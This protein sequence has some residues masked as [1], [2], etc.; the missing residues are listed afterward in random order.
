MIEKNFRNLLYCALSS[1]LLVGCDDG[2][3]VVSAGH[4]VDR[5][6]GIFATTMRS[7]DA[8]GTEVL[9]SGF[10]KVL[11][12]KR[13]STETAL[14]SGVFTYVDELWVGLQ[15]TTGEYIPESIWFGG[16]G[17]GTKPWLTHNTYYWPD[18][19]IACDF[20]AVYPTSGPDI[21]V[22][23]RVGAK[24]PVRYLD[25]NNGNGKTDL[26]LAATTSNKTQAV[27]DALAAGGT[28]GLAKLLFHHSLSRVTL[29]AKL[30]ADQVPQLSVTVNSVEL[31][32]VLQMGTF[33]F[34]DLPNNPGDAPLIGVWTAWGVPQSMILYNDAT[35]VTLT[36]AAQTL[37][38]A[39]NA[40]M[41][42][43][44]RLTAWENT[45]NTIAANNS[46]ASPG[47]YL[48]IGCTIHIPE[49][50]GS[51]TDHGYVYVPFTD[52]WAL[53]KNYE[54]TLQFGGG[55]DADGNIILQPVTI[56]STVTPWESANTT[57]PNE[58]WI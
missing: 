15:A 27:A 51:F 19:Y 34:Q 35:G 28:D 38:D 54:Y 41:F 45:A 48:K 26:L 18:H 30:K 22:E 16:D 14:N 37:T 56:T 52:D 21:E 13:D 44:Q 20:Y 40:I 31:C 8:V 53:S 6:L 2:S 9:T 36:D 4:D 12:W 25:Y 32:N 29:K 55:Y 5:Q 43:P 47:S 57:D 49:Y 39:A 3:T 46:L 24:R 42:I 7:G 1:L 33:R 50:A 23:P 10:F 58:S 11:A 17:D